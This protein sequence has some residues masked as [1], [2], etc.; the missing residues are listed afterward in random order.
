MSGRQNYVLAGD[1]DFGFSHS[2]RGIRVATE[3]LFFVFILIV[4]FK[5]GFK[6]YLSA[7][8]RHGTS[9]D[10]TGIKSSILREL[11]DGKQNL[12]CGD[13]QLPPN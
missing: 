8:D 2:A 10:Q 4:L 9:G 7:G 6:R 12:D 13:A 1:D 3:G 11:S 5:Q